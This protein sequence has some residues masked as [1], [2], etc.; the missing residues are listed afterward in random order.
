MGGGWLYQWWPLEDTVTKGRP[1]S[2]LKC[3]THTHTDSHTHT[4]IHAYTH[5][6]AGRELMAQSSAVGTFS[7][8]SLRTS[9]RDLRPI[10]APG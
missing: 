4:R 10:G 3:V 6:Q 2:G 1:W 7:P 8:F 9:V 5:T